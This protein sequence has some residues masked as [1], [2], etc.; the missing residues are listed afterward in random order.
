[1][2]SLRIDNFH[3]EFVYGYYC[4]SIVSNWRVSWIKNFSH[5]KGNVTSLWPVK[6]MKVRNH[7][8][9]AS[10]ESTEQ[11]FIWILFW[12][13]RKIGKW[14]N[15]TTRTCHCEMT[16]NWFSV[17][18]AETRVLGAG[19]SDYDCETK[20]GQPIRGITKRDDLLSLKMPERV[21]GR[22]PEV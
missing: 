5:W 4:Q 3:V 14:A 22:T 18:W 15:R 7:R 16:D 8:L 13:F 6:T 1:M 11:I 19:V 12:G 10:V 2:C 20:K 9:W 17:P 21:A